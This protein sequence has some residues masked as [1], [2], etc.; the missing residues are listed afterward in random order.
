MLIAISR[1]G[2]TTETLTAVRDFKKSNRGDVI[3]IT[4]YPDSPLV[5][6][7]DIAISISSGQ[8]ISIAQTK[9]FASM[10][11]AV[12]AVAYLLKREQSFNNYQ[13]GLVNTGNNLI[14]QY[15][16][17]ARDFGNAQDIHQEF[18]VGSGPHYGLACEVSLK[19]KEMSQTV[20]E[21]FHFM[22]FRHGPISMVNK[23]TLVIG[24][25][26]EKLMLLRWRFLTMYENLE[27]RF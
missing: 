23:N 26:S 4:N 21:P 5:S 1:S 14:K 12:N 16:T 24:L 7:S 11:V 25:I 6:E 10:L 17:V 9:S 27:A 15:E 8:E 20:C 3:S 18:F 19:L 2:S 22:E 13:V